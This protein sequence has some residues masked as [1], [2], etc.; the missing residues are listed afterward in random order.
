MDTLL[1]TAIA[2]EK[3][4]HKDF[5]YTLENDTSVIINF[6]AHGFHHLMGLQK[7]VDIDQVRKAEVGS[8][9][10][11]LEART[12]YRNIRN[13][14]ITLADIQKSKHFHEIENR[15]RFFSQINN[16]VE[17]E[18]IIIDFDKELLGFRSNLS[19]AEYLLHKKGNMNIHLNL[20]LGQANKRVNMLFPLTFITSPTDHYTYG[21]RA[22][23][24]LDM[25]TVLLRREK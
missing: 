10:I 2:Y 6:Q 25:K 23:K 4:L 11:Q 8:P 14:L 1:E 20:F 19:K 7:L 3:L 24:I 16:L 22:L 9:R 13:G 21:Q 12:I 5:I 18:K 17:F 15:L